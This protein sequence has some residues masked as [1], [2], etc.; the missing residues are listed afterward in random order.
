MEKSKDKRLDEKER[1]EA[2]I[3][4]SLAVVRMKEVHRQIEEV[5]K[6]RKRSAILSIIERLNINL[7]VNKGILEVFTAIQNKFPEK[8]LSQKLP[9]GYNSVALNSI[10]KTYE[11]IRFDLQRNFDAKNEEF[12][13]LFPKQTFNS[14]TMQNIIM[15]VM[16]MTLQM[17]DMKAYCLRLL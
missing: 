1:L 13:R 4:R 9:D 3:E 10:V 16:Q 15:S 2:E 11:S 17:M 12:D 6:S 8:L 7:G 14:E 5:E